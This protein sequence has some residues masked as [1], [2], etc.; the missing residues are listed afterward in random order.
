MTS[1]AFDGDGTVGATETET[2]GNN[3]WAA[4]IT[5][6]T[7]IRRTPFPPKNCDRVISFANSWIS[8][9]DGMRWRRRSDNVMGAD[10]VCRLASDV[11]RRYHLLISDHTARGATMLRSLASLLVVMSTVG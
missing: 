1:S 5:L 4:Q 2:L 7:R 10:G 6:V 11:L 3:V 8:I 9:R